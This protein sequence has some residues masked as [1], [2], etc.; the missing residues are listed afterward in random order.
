MTDPLLAGYLSL[1]KDINK[2]DNNYEVENQEGVISTLTDEL[3][4][5]MTDEELIDLKK[6]WEKAWSPIQQALAKS[7]DDNENY[8]LG[9]QY[10]ASTPNEG[11]ALVDNLIF[12]S[13]ET[14]LPLAT[15]PKADPVVT[16]D[17]TEEGEALAN[18]VR[19]M[20]QSWADNESYNIKLKSVCRYWALY[21]LG[22]MKLGWSIQKNDI[23]VVAIRPQK[24][25][26][27]PDATIESGE[28]TG[29]YI[30][31][32]RKDTARNLVKRFP[33]A[34]KYIL[35]QCKEKLGTKMQYIEWWTDDYVFWTM[36]DQVLAKA[37]NPHWNYNKTQD[38][39]NEFGSI[40]A[41]E[42]K[43]KNHFTYSKKPYAFLSVFSL[44]TRPFDDTNLIQQ[45][46]PLQ[47]LI[48][49]RLRQ[50]D[51]NADK[52]NGGLAV[53]GD[54]FTKEQAAGVSKAVEKGGTI[55]VPTGDVGRGVVR[56]SAD[57]LP[58]FVY[59]SL[60]DY[61]NELRNIFGVRGSTAQGTIQDKTV[62]G[63]LQI[64]GQD[65]DRIGGGISTFLEQLS[66][67][68]YNYVVQMMYV[69]YDEEHVATIIGKDR[70]AEY[71]ALKSADLVSKMTVSVKDGSMI[72]KD[73]LT[74][75]EEIITLWEGGA[76]DPITFFEKL[77]FPDPKKTAEQLYMWKADP[78][79]LFPEVTQK[80][81]EIAAQQAEQQ[82]PDPAVEQQA[83]MSAQQMEILKQ[84][85]EIEKA[86]GVQEIQNAQ[87]KHQV[88]MLKQQQ[89]IQTNRQKLQVNKK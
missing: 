35:D 56:L 36:N 47:D 6:D 59:E 66:D 22:V 13:L 44:G 12:E 55:F 70:T 34:S 11:H 61:R 57:A 53:S 33:K 43:G 16:G 41:Q 65:A 77:D 31:E 80:Q 72:P 76:I 28:Y 42:V 71:I 20:I 29:E 63:K 4:L 14:F 79:L 17:N 3:E 52:T 62:R 89:A 1:G 25:I 88:E 45:V 27:D 85:G 68:V 78:A 40:Q 81:Q 7:Q 69:Y 48:N 49:K 74:Q 51:K 32:Y 64:K 50:I 83:Q 73:P 38:V 67:V 75:R 58:S 86:K 5:S 54:S 15:R 39:T 46:L 23:T 87:Q 26:L 10:E 60:I 37:K 30:G 8:W 21:K 24:L 82:Q 9:K 84:K 18:K 2:T 19:K